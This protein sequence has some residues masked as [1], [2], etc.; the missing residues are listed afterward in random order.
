[1]PNVRDSERKAMVL[2]IAREA[3]RESVM[4]MLK[5]AVHDADA[6]LVC[7]VLPVLERAF[8]M[9]MYASDADG[10][11]AVVSD[12]VSLPGYLKT[13][14]SVLVK[15]VPVKVKSGECKIEDCPTCFF[16]SICERVKEVKLIERSRSLTDQLLV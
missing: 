11:R 7:K 9:D 4:Q 2:S 14:E 15:G 1:M 13:T 8:R 12:A 10:Q 16:E 3:T 6:D 5:R